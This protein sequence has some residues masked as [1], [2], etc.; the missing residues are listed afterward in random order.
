MKKIILSLSLAVAGLMASCVDKNEEV[1]AESK[2]GWLHGSIYEELKNPIGDGSGLEGTFTNYLRLIDDLGYAETLSRTGSKTVFPANDAAFER[3]FQSND[4]GVASYEQ[5]TEAQKKLLLYSSM[6]DNALLTGMLSNVSSGSTSTQ[7]GQ[8]LKHRTN[9]SVIDSIQFLKMSEMPRNNKFWA[10]HYNSAGMYVVSDN[11]VPMMVHFTR[12]QMV[13]NSITVAGENSDFQI[14]TGSP[15]SVGDVFIYDDKVI[16]PDITCINGYIHQ[17][18]NVLLQPGNM[19]QVI[20][21]DK[22]TSLFSR[23]L[24]YFSAP[25]FDQQTTNN[26][27]DWALQNKR[28]PIDS[29]FQKRYFSSYSQGSSLVYDPDGNVV[30][31]YLSY[32]PGWNQYYPSSSYTTSIDRTITDIGAMFVPDDKAFEDYFLAGGS[33]AYLIDIYGKYRGSENT[34]ANLA[35]NLDSLHSKNPEILKKFIRN[36]QLKSFVQ[37]V[38]SKFTTIMND[39]SENMGMNMSYLKQKSG[40]GY[41]VKIANNG[42]VYV[43]NKMIAPDEYQAVLAPSS[44]YPDMKVMDWAV[45]DRE[46]LGVDFKFYLL[47][48]SA[49]YAFFIPD[50]EAFDFYYVNPVTL[51]RSQAEALRFFYDEKNSSKIKLRV[52]NYS[53]DLNTNTVG[54]RLGEIDLN[55]NFDEVKSQLVDILNYHTV[56]LKAGKTIGDGNKYFKTKHGGEIYIEGGNAVGTEVSS[57]AQIDNGMEKPEIETVY[58]QTNGYAYRLNRVIQAPRNSVWK[59][60]SGNDRFSEFLTACSGFAASDLLEWAGISSQEDGTTKKSEQDR[61]QV[62]V[63][64]YGSGNTKYNNACVDENV[65]MFNTYNYTLYAPDNDAMEE[66]YAMGLP[67]WTE[68]QALMEKY[69]ATEEETEEELMDKEKAY[70]MINTLREFVRYH[71]Q[72]VS[73]YADKVFDED[74]NSYA[75]MHSDDLGVAT[76]IQVMGGNNRLVVTDGAGIAHTVDANNTS[77]VS[78]K[79]ARDYWFDAPQQQAKSIVTSSFCAVHEIDRPF[80]FGGSASSPKRYDADWSSAKAQKNAVQYY[81]RLNANNKL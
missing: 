72:N 24:D 16:H 74:G 34:V 36:L 51:G 68:I 39:A 66:A 70:V 79:M 23:V 8:A 71:F 59:T 55:S 48:M 50:D 13:N 77:M 6:L 69:T 15:Y 32:D 17:V 54:Q 18:E 9:I 14:L 29:I 45:Q 31:S 52:E 80:Y 37:T 33:G 3:F 25:Y 40:G 30:N 75:T 41:D 28:D 65:R 1:D 21:K 63:S 76:N 12:E 78:N 5:L 19:T 73:L 10:K 38:P 53:Y 58:P 20:A 7:N 4:W 60:L 61:Y 42:V 27:N 67:R 62:F 2:P 47:A 35:E 49:N 81:K 44:V 43:L 11:T 64:S 22:E 46:Y 56:V 26:Y 57:G